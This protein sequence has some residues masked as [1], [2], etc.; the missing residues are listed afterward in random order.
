[1]NSKN[2]RTVFFVSDRT[3]LTAETLGRS[4]IS[5]FN[6]IEFQRVMLPYIDSADKARAASA[7]IDT[8][9]QADGTRPLVFSTM[10]HPEYRN[11]LSEC[12][13]LFL[14][15]FDVF[16]DP[17]QAELGIP[18]SH[19]SGLSH[20]AGAG[21]S[22]RMNAVNYALNHDDGG[23]TRDLPSADLILVGVS[24]CGKTP[25]SLYLALQFGI[26]AANYPLVEEDFASK[27]LPAPLKLLR[28]KLYGLTIT[29]ERLHQIRAERSPDSRYAS[30][31][32]CRKEI[33]Q[34]ENIMI[35]FNIPRL[36]VTSM[37]VEEIATTIVHQTG[38]RQ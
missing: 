31:E 35:M 20:G 22:A 3:G 32:N 5:Q 29:P 26:H 27:D 38:L 36:D 18:P 24:R 9:A 37:S 23:I 17:L 13:G 33:R 14:D 2:K 16:I 1:M 4:L 11:I 21:Y 30:L 34:A 15:L 19:E 28:N 10:I 8:A 25:T 12:D 7:R 6:G